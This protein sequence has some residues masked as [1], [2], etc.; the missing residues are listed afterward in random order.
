MSRRSSLPSHAHSS[1]TTDI[2]LLMR[3][4]S[5]QYLPT[6]RLNAAARRPMFVANARR[7]LGASSLWKIWAPY[8]APILALIAILALVS[9]SVYR[10]VR[11]IFSKCALERTLPSQV[12]ALQSP[13]TRVPSRLRSKDGKTKR[14]SESRQRQNSARR[15]STVR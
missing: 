1:D 9:G 10:I 8:I 12:T 13:G 3:H 11:C 7:Y 4:V 14:R 6:A 5:H 15:G 2:F